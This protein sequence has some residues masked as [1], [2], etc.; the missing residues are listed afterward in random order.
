MSVG[1]GDGPTYDLEEA[2][3]LAKDGSLHVT[4]AARE[5]AFQNDLYFDD[6]SAILFSLSPSDFYKTMEAKKLPGSFQDVYHPT[7]RGVQLYYKIQIQ[8][9]SE[10]KVIIIDC[11]LLNEE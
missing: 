2:K 7:Y 3:R 4:G 11:K 5:A 9:S 1:R 6:I 10:K 8:T